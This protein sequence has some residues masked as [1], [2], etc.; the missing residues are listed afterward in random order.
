M[1]VIENFISEQVDTENKYPVL[2]KFHLGSSFYSNTFP[3][4]KNIGFTTIIG[5]FN[6]ENN[7]FNIIIKNK[8]NIEIAKGNE[9]KCKLVN[10][11]NNGI[12]LYN[13][14]GA[15]FQNENS[16]YLIELWNEENLLKTF[17]LKGE[18]CIY[19]IYQN[20]DSS[21]TINIGED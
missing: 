16:Y 20:L 8:E 2:Y 17:K 19:K 18:N 21:G 10:E 6:K 1:K 9:F 11:N 13:V 4:E 15:Y 12:L 5:D 14:N 7:K 3:I